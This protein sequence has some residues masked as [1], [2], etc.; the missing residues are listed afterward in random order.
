MEQRDAAHTPQHSNTLLAPR[1]LRPGIRALLLRG[2]SDFSLRSSDG[3]VVLEL[4]PVC[5]RAGSL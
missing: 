1:G 4:L 3:G 5:V 2:T